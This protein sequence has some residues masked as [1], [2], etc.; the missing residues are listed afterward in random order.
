MQPRETFLTPMETL[1]LEKFDSV[2]ETINSVLNQEVRIIMQRAEADQISKA[3]KNHQ[4]LQLEKVGEFIENIQNLER[5]L[6]IL[7]NDELSEL[8][9]CY[10]KLLLTEEPTSIT[11]K[12]KEMHSGIIQDIVRADEFIRMVKEDLLSM[13]VIRKSLF[14]KSHNIPTESK[15]ISEYDR[16]IVSVDLPVEIKREEYLA[17][18]QGFF[19]PDSPFPDEKFF[20]PQ[21]QSPDTRELKETDPQVPKK[22][23]RIPTI[24]TFR[25]EEIEC[26]GSQQEQLSPRSLSSSK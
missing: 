3:F 16:P 20:S 26:R 25:R 14:N 22:K 2:K 11:F 24:F 4:A 15:N 18:S 6:K 19:S 5:S 17:S 7:S 21:N 10:D 9:G 1:F 12:I 23:T 8:L 13:E